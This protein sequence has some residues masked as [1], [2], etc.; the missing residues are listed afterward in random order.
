MTTIR[1]KFYLCLGAAA[2]AISLGACQTMK[3][4]Y[5]S[6]KSGIVSLGP[7]MDAWLGHPIKDLIESWGDPDA[8]VVLGDGMDAYTWAVG[9]GGCERTFTVRQT[10]IV[11]VSDVNCTN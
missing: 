11:G 7:D 3:S 2:L 5:E 4:G 10:K 6:T 9:D 1:R 8:K